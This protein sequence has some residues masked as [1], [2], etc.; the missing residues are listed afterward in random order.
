[1]TDRAGQ[2]TFTCIIPAY[3]E[4]QRIGCVLDA[5][6]GHPMLAMVVVVDDGS[7][8]ATGA[9]ARA[10]GA[11]VIR[12]AGNLG[13]TNAVLEGLRRVD[14]SHVVLIDADLAGL[15]AQALTAL[16]EPVFLRAY[17]CSISLRGN[18]PL[19]WR[20]IGVDY[21]SGERVLPLALLSGRLGEMTALPRFGFEV[22]LNRLIIA[23]SASVA[24]VGWPAVA[25]PSKASKRG[26]MAGIGADV[27]M[28]ADIFRTTG[29]VQCLRQILALRRLGKRRT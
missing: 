25:S 3:N 26:L 19:A 13:K 23:G 6:I 16:I 10:R 27:A 17:D 11:R 15:T 22:Y 2:A 29:P 7:T 18:A 14:T 5:V 24:I 8:D 9:V 21:I 4:A 28:M 20:W 12:T 1:M